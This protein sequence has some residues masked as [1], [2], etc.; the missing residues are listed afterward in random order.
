MNDDKS[1]IRAFIAISLPKGTKSFLND[2]QEQL[3]K[4]GIRASWPKPAAMHLTLKFLG[5]IKGHEIEAIKTCMTKSVKNIPKH[6]LFTSGIGVFPSV[7]RAKVIW[8]GIRGQTD[9]LEKLENCLEKTLFGDMA[10]KIENKRFLPHLTLARIKQPIFPNKMDR[11]L[12]KFKDSRSSEF[13]ISNITLF[14][15]ELKSSGA[16]YKSIFSAPLFKNKN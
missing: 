13:L 9:I 10:I 14:Q 8:S 4:S 11:L 6:T 16:I 7:K 5:N 3:R 15:S 2:L 1:T 12:Q